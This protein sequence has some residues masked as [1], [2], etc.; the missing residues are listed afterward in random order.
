[1]HFTV[2]TLFPQL[3]SSYLNDS[4]LKRA[5]EKDI[6]TIDFFRIRDFAKNK[7]RQV[8][9]RPYGGGA[10]ML[11]MCQPLFDA[12]TKTKENNHGPVIYLTPQGKVLKQSNLRRLAKLKEVILL[13]GRYEGID[14]RVRDTFVDEEV[15]LGKYVVTGGELPA[16]VLI[17]GI[18]RLLPGALGDPNS[19]D[20]DSFSLSFKGK[21]EYPQYTKPA[22]YKG[23]KVPE[24][25]LNG[26]HGEIEKWR[27]ERLR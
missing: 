6:L 3:F 9:D 10:G 18:T 23:L 2:L 17:D 5:I 25:L 27:R 12:I 8:D 21:K 7:H 15:S 1:M 20:E 4:I 14:Q 26:N 22:M 19:K 16:L 24:V 13:C 11:L